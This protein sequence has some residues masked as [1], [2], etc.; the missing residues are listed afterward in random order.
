MAAYVIITAMLAKKILTTQ[1]QNYN[2]IKVQY[3]TKVTISRLS[4]AL[5][6]LILKGPLMS[7]KWMIGVFLLT[8]I[9]F[10]VF[11]Q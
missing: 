4:N 1:S 8:I 7:V 11:I 10:H 5:G 9:K 6:F 2:Y 3:Y